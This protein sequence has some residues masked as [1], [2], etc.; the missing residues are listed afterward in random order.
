MLIQNL[1]DNVG[2]KDREEHAIGSDSLRLALAFGGGIL[3][4]NSYIAQTFFSDRIDPYAI[5]LSA[6]I[7]S[8]ESRLLRLEA[9]HRSLRRRTAPLVGVVIAA[10]TAAALPQDPTP[11]T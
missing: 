6:L 1:S 11:P 9:A 5:T 10:L 7:G 2:V 4:L 3:V 8:F